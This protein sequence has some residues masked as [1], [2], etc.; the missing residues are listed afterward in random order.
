MEEAG[1]LIGDGVG[2]ESDSDQ[3]SS[4]ASIRSSGDDIA[5][6]AE[7]LRNDTCCLAGLGPLLENLVCDIPAG[8]NTQTP[9]TCTWH[10]T[11][12]DWEFHDSGIGSTLTLPDEAVMSYS[13]DGSSLLPALPDQRQNLKQHCKP[14]KPFGGTAQKHRCKPCRRTFSTR[15]YLRWHQEKN[16]KNAPMNEDSSHIIKCSICNKSEDDGNTILCQTCNT[17]QHFASYYPKNSKDALSAKSSHNYVECLRTSEPKARDQLTQNPEES[18]PKVQEPKTLN[19]A[20]WGS[21]SLAQKG[22]KVHAET[23]RYRCGSIQGDS[24]IHI[25]HITRC[26]RPEITNYLCLCGRESVDVGDHKKHIRDRSCERLRKTTIA[27][28]TKVDPN[29]PPNSFDTSLSSPST[30]V[31]GAIDGKAKSVTTSLPQIRVREPIREPEDDN[32][33]KLVLY[34]LPPTKVALT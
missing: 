8:E 28:S 18:R 30:A 19:P 24:D 3:S 21:A 5:E 4:G 23:F 14:G 13:H 10:P 17:R 31:A 7:D 16:H 9:L 22:G 6:I 1:Q 2:S 26:S 27:G 20:T 15:G 34:N 25:I 12:F 11:Q 32:F 29:F 33:S